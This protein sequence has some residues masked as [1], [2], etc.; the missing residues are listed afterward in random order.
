MFHESRAKRGALRGHLPDIGSLDHGGRALDLDYGPIQKDI[1]LDRRRRSEHAL[2]SDHPNLNHF[3]GGQG[4]YE[5]NDAR[6]REYDP[7]DV[8]PGL[9]H[10][11]SPGADAAPLR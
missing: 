8:L 6:V 4:D 11:L 5:G 2:P 3:S 10:D 1:I 7:V 9:R